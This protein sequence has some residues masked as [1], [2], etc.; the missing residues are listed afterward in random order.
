MLKSANWF[1]R[2]YI[3]RIDLFE[4][5]HHN[6]PHPRCTTLPN[7]GGTLQTSIAAQIGTFSTLPATLSHLASSLGRN[8]AAQ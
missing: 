1:L 7:Q 5:L 2:V 4:N 8:S 6:S 3:L